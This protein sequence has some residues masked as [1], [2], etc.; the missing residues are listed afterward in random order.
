MQDAIAIA[1][2]AVAAAW[3]AR[4][5]AKRLVTPPCQPPSAGP[6]GTD[7]FVPLDS[8]THPK[9]AGRPEGRPAP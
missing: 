9:Q 5:L 4:S 8:L 3:L 1:I 2:A 6:P 7:G